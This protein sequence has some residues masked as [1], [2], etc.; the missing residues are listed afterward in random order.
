M[1]IRPLEKGEAP[2]A[3]RAIYDELERRT[4]RVG[5]F[6]KMLAH[7]P[8]VLRTFTAFYQQ[9]WAPSALS[10]RLKSL[11]YLRVSILNGCVY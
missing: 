5:N 7:K 2:E 3:A 10:D 4:G 1:R 11:A 8:E 6:Y 9:V